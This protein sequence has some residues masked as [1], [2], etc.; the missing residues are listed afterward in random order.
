MN[1]RIL[2][3]AALAVVGAAVVCAAI[4]APQASDKL[5]GK[6]LYRERCGMCHQGIG[7]AVSLLSRRPGDTSKGLLEDRKDLSAEFVFTAAR[8]GIGN[9]P[10]IARGEVSD[11]EL[12]SI[13]DYLTRARP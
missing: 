1:I 10:R 8:T 13:A 9:M 2:K 11:P 3:P 5:D 12:A 4:S 7:M 6:A